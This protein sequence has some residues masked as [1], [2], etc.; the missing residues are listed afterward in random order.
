MPLS[1]HDPSLDY[2]GSWGVASR[3]WPT[4]SFS[5]EEQANRAYVIAWRDAKV[6]YGSYVLVGTD[7]RLETQA[8][9]EAV[10]LRL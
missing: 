1:Q 10:L 7:L 6:P 4:I 5:T 2:G 8:Q 9:K 3:G